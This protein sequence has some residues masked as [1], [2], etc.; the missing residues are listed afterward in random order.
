MGRLSTSVALLALVVLLGT[1]A[2]VLAGAA[3]PS[4]TGSP[5]VLFGGD[6]YVNQRLRKYLRRESPRK[7]LESLI[8][9]TRDVDLH[10]ANL[11]GPITRS[12]DTTTSKQYYLRNHPS[13]VIPVLKALSVDGVSLAN[14][15]MMDYRVQGLRDTIRHLHEQRI[16]HAG[17]GLNRRAAEGMAWFN[18]RNQNIGLLAFSNTFP[19]GFWSGPDR[20]GTAYGDVDRIRSRVEAVADRA[21]YTLVSFHWGGELRSSPKTYQIELAHAAV[22][23]G[24]DVV[25][26]HHP[27]V[28]QPVERFGEGLIFYSLGNYLFTTLTRDVQHGLMVEVTLRD[29]R[30]VKPRYHLLNV[31]NYQV[32]YRPRPVRSFRR[33]SK[34]AR[35]LDR[36][37]FFRVTDRDIPVRPPPDDPV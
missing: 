24:A 36:P 9:I 25:F 31:N 5:R 21:D 32:R 12:S 23:A 33:V 3:S 35:F 17:A 26:G 19:R 4:G 16:R 27:H 14:N 15:H 18:R 22:R 1:G 28:I 13:S 34:L 8:P 10:L 6:L 30:A 20:P 7:V 2:W 11:E 37:N 29:G